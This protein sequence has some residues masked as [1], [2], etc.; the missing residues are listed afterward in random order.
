MGKTSSNG[1][2][3]IEPNYDS[4]SLEELREVYHK[5]DR[6]K[7]PDRFK[8]V[9]SLLNESG[10]DEKLIVSSEESD[11]R[12]YG[13]LGGVLHYIFGMVTESPLWLS[14]LGSPVCLFLVLSSFEDGVFH[15][16]GSDFERI[17]D[18]V[19]YWFFTSNA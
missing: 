2:Y 8:K 3:M 1:S 7:W 11:L 17:H 13:V 5:I 4:Y 14:M 12:K 16:R 6:E 9:E 19:M 18:P 10:K 15:V